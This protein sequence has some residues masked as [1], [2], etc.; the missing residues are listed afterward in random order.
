VAVNDAVTFE[1]YSFK[2]PGNF[3]ESGNVTR[4]IRKNHRGVSHN[5]QNLSYESVKYHIPG[6]I[7]GFHFRSQFSE[8]FYKQILMNVLS[9]DPYDL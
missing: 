1:V 9:S 4:V 7:K 6:K 8:A 2:I 3:P 5:R